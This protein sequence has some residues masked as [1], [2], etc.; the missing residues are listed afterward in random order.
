M[1]AIEVNFKPSIQLTGLFIGVGLSALGILLL[2]YVVGTMTSQT[3]IW[4]LCVLIVVAT[5]YAVCLH[6]LLWLPWSCVSV[7]ILGE[8]LFYKQKNGTKFEA[9]VLPSST[10]TAYLTV[11]NLQRVDASEASSY[12]STSYTKSLFLWC[13]RKWMTNTEIIILTDSC[14]DAEPYRQLR[15]WLRLAA[16]PR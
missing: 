14:I 4:P 11:I 7:K 15:V 5:T 9:F 6:G 3:L 10:V 13:Q 2:L 8:L 16:L 12:L 1:H